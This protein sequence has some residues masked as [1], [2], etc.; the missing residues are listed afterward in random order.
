MLH[1]L[2]SSIDGI[3]CC[4]LIRSLHRIRDEPLE[5]Y[6]IE[7]E[8]EK[9]EKWQIDN[10]MERARKTNT[11][12]WEVPLVVILEYFKSDRIRSL[13]DETIILWWLILPPGSRECDD[14]LETLAY[15]KLPQRSAVNFL[16]RAESANS[17]SSLSEKGRKRIRSTIQAT[18]LHQIPELPIGTP[19]S[20]PIA[21]QQLVVAD[22]KKLAKFAEAFAS[23]L[24][25]FPILQSPRV[26]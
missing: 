19:E 16:A 15:Y 21:L 7:Q 12:L 4:R 26:Y 1:I 18:R 2:P 14:F 9:I 23:E 8:S 11:L 3:L 25:D 24:P 13:L 22:Y 5:I 6:S 17:W 20:L 10:V